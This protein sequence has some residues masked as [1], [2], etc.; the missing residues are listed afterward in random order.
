LDVRWPGVALSEIFWSVHIQHTKPKLMIFATE[1]SLVADP[2]NITAVSPG[3][4]PSYG[5]TLLVLSGS[6]FSG[7]PNSQTSTQVFATDMHAPSV[8]CNFNGTI[9]KAISRS[10]TTIQVHF[11]RTTDHFPCNSEI[12]VDN[13][14]VF[15]SRSARHHHAP[16]EDMFMSRFL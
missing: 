10:D 2:F 1:Q 9:V 11:N 7:D 13:I 5:G 16:G 4:G 3:F 15:A 12:R 8:Y 6:G 14:L